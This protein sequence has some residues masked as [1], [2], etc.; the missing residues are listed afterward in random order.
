RGNALTQELFGCSVDELQSNPMRRSLGFHQTLHVSNIQEKKQRLLSIQSHIEH[1]QRKSGISFTERHYLQISQQECATR[2]HQLELPFITN[3]KNNIIET[4]KIPSKREIGL[5]SLDDLQEIQQLCTSAIGS[6]TLTS[7]Q[8]TRLQLLNIYISEEINK[9]ALGA[10]N[11]S[12]GSR[13][14]GY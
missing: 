5:M 13:N 3:L 10:S 2:L 7:T 6:D 4:Q 9:R 8:R 12:S 14:H 1:R 11:T